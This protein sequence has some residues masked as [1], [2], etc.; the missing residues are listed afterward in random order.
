MQ[1]RFGLDVG[2]EESHRTARLGQAEPHADKVGFVAHEHRD[3]VSLLQLGGVVEDVGQPVTT[4]V[5]VPV[6]V[7]A[8]IVDHEGLVGDALRLL[9]EPIQ[10]GAHAGCQPEELQLQAVP[11]DL[12][13]KEEVPPQVGQTE[14]LDAKSEHQSG[15]ERRDAAQREKHAAAVRRT[16]GRWPLVQVTNT[17]SRGEETQAALQKHLLHNA[18]TPEHHLRDLQNKYRSRNKYISE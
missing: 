14:P 2:V 18:H 3:A 17:N 5:D 8:A 9:D 7:H 11:E 16:R 12:Q 4:A 6:R 10:D 1:Q 15:T 13:Q